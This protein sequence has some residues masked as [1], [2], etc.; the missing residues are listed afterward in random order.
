[1]SQSQDFRTIMDTDAR[2]TAALARSRELGEQGIQVAAYLDGREIVRASDGIADHRTQAPVT[3][4]TL[5]NVFSVSKAVT[6]TALHV[7]AERGLVDYLA[8]VAE[9]WPEFATHGK[10]NIRVRDVLSH[11]AGIPWM[12]AG[13]TPVRQADWSWMVHAIEELVP[14]APPNTEN[15]YHALVWGWIVGEL[16]RRTDPEHRSFDS[17]V[18][19]EILR[20]LAIDDLHLG[21][22]KEHDGRRAWLEGGEFSAEAPEATRLGMPQAVYPGSKVYNGEIARRTINPSAGMI[23]SASAMARFFAM[24]ANGGELDGV[25]LLS[26][27]RVEMM[28][29]P[30]EGANDPDRLMGAPVPVGAYGLWLGGEGMASTPVVGTDPRVLLHPGAGGSV[31]WA[32]LDT[33]LAVAICHN[34][35][36][37]GPF[38]PSAH[39]FRPIAE[40]VRAVAADLREERVG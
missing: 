39:P 17:F 3:E 33:G 37:A 22:P 35:M 8:P 36:H 38:G 23:G 28:A 19:D 11:R 24:L 25:R 2:V 27:E 30:R 7:Q 4:D 20:P 29:T 32:E 1:M 15:C 26:Q 40:S 5:F 18:A 21:L 10:G 12:P 31:A 9:Y 13:V 14:V 16:V 6:A 34:R